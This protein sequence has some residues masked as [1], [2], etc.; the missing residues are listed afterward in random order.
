MPVE[1][2]ICCRSSRGIDPEIGDGLRRPGE[3]APRELT[4]R[5]RAAPTG[6]RPGRDRA[7]GLGPRDDFPDRVD[8]AEDVALTHERYGLGALVD[9][10]RRRQRPDRAGRRRSTRSSAASPRSLARQLPWH[11][12]GVVPISVTTTSSPG[13]PLADR[14]GEQVQSL[15]DVLGEDDLARIGG[16]EEGRDLLA[17]PLVQRGRFLGESVNSRWTLAYGARRTRA[18][19]PARP[20]ASGSSPRCRGRPAARRRGCA[21]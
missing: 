19:R 9:Q 8:G 6:R 1:P 4:P 21:G 18:R 10:A 11:E 12:V 7:D 3:V 14:A 17:S 16:A 2:S 15:R 13:Q 5:A 20:A